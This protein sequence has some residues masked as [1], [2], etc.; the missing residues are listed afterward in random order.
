MGVLFFKGLGC[1]DV[2]MADVSPPF[3]KGGEGWGEGGFE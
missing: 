2:K 3:L 1:G